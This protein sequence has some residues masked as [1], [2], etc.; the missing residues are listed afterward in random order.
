[1]LTSFCCLSYSLSIAFPLKSGAC[2]PPATP[3]CRPHGASLRSA[4]FPI[5]DLVFPP[6]LH[7]RSCLSSGVA[8]GVAPPSRSTRH[9][10]SFSSGCQISRFPELSYE[11]EPIKYFRS[12]QTGLGAFSLLNH[13][14]YNT[15]TQVETDTLKTSQVLVI[16]KRRVYMMV[17]LGIVAARRLS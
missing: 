7:P 8:S 1:M 5:L 14:K 13:S 2:S 4:F 6:V 11:H 15:K 10:G 16:S 17:T 12:N 9:K 3:D